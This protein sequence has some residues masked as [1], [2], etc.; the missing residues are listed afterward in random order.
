MIYVTRYHPDKSMTILSLYYD[1]LI[2]KIEEYEGRKYLMVNDYT[3]DKVLDKMKSIGI[4]KHDDTKILI[5]SGDKFSDDLT[6]INAF[7]LIK[8]VNKDGDKFYPRLFLEEVL[9]DA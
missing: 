9:H 5:D 6:L 4:E 7:I 1:E 8:C 3:L 2:G